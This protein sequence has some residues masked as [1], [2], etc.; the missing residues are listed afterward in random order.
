MPS[1]SPKAKQA[2]EPLTLEAEAQ[3]VLDELWADK[4]IPFALRL[5]KLTKSADE[6]TLHFYDSRMRKAHVPLS[7]E[8]SFKEMV[9]EAVLARAEQMSGPLQ[10]PLRK[11]L[12]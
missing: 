1:K 12:D 10:Q 3:Q 11:D 2:T 7:Q 9:R 8:R 6:Y 5:G 4:A